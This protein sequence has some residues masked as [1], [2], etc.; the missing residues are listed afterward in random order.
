MFNERSFRFPFYAMENANNRFIERFLT[1]A[2]TKRSYLTIVVGII[3][4]WD[5]IARVYDKCNDEYRRGF[6]E[7]KTRI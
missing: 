6:G 3:S 4:E 5:A 7:R 2:R 1:R